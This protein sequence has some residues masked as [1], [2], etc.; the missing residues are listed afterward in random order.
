M[1]FVTTAFLLSICVAFGGVA[2][3]INPVGPVP[4]TYIGYKIGPVVPSL[5]L[6]Y[7]NLNGKFTYSEEDS[8]GY[9]YVTRVDWKGSILTPTLGTKV[10]LGA[11]DLRPFARVSLGLPFLTSI[12][13]LATDEDVQAD[14]E[15]IIEIIR[16]GLKQPILF[17]A[18]A[19]VEHFFAD[20][21]S[22]GAE[23]CYRYATAGFNWADFNDRGS[24]EWD[25][26]EVDVRTHFGS[27]G[28]G[29]WLN[30]YF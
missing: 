3:G 16:V 25:R 27:T 22:I 18:G 9:D 1:R 28:V 19:G 5:S 23:F 10:I 15:E 8:D 17:T 21:F 12:D 4:E 2:F 14:I 30:Y 13:V 7:F 20:R 24:G 11:S 29:L 26:E 6:H